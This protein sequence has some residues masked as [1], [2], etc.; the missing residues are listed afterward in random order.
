MGIEVIF[1]EISSFGILMREIAA[2]AALLR[3]DFLGSFGVVVREIA[4]SLR[5]S[6]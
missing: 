2:V 4:T 5:S 3:N 1:K 6:Q